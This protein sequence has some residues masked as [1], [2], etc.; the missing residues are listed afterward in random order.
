MRRPHRAA[1]RILWPA[2]AAM[3]ALGLVLALAWR[4]AIPIETQAGAASGR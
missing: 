1:H 3:V 2:L 4:P